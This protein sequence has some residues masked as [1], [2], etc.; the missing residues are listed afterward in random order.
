M[1]ATEPAPP[2]HAAPPVAPF[3]FPSLPGWRTWWAK[4]DRRPIYAWARDHI[5]LPEG[6]YAIPGPFDV[7]RSRYLIEPFDAIHDECVREITANGAVQTGKTLLADIS[8]PYFVANDPGAMM[9]T[10]QSDKDAAEHVLTRVDRLWRTIAPLAPL[11]PTN[12]H[13]DTN[14]A[15]YF[16]T[17]FLLINGAN[18]NSLQSKSIR[19]KFN[20]E[21][22]LPQW[23][24]LY[25]QAARRVSAYARLGTSKIINDSQAGHV[26]DILDQR[27]H[28]G[29]FA[30]WSAPCP[31]CNQVHPLRITQKLPDG[32][33]YGMIW[34][35]DARRPDGTYNIG[36][37]VETIR[38]RCACGHELPDTEHTRQYWNTHGLYVAENPSAPRHIRSYWWGSVHVHPMAEL[39]AEK[40][41]ALNLAHTGNMDDLKTFRQQRENEPWE[42]QHLTV[43]LA[44]NPDGYYTDPANITQPTFLWPLGSIDERLAPTHLALRHKEK[45]PGERYR[46]LMADRQRGMAGD[47]PHRW[48]E[49]RAWFP[50]G[51][52][53]Q[54]T[55]TRVDTKEAMRD[56]QHRYAVPDRCV[57][58]DAR[59]E[60]HKVYEECA[61]YGWI[62]CWGHTVI[63]SWVHLQPNPAGAHLPPVKIRLP[64]SPWQ[65]TVVAGKTV[66][67]LLFA[68][69]YCKDIL[70]NLIAGRGVKHE[71]PTD[72]LPAYLEHLKCEH[73]EQKGA[74]MTWVKRHSTAPNHG[75]DTS[76][77]GI[78]FALLMKLLSMP[79][80][81]ATEPAAGE[82]P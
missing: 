67:Y 6:A 42:E 22:W 81:A 11:Y 60:T 48:C 32:T 70:A 78:A 7:T 59:F 65:S 56:L 61:E 55:F 2:A 58:M 16:A 52:S 68:S 26:G 73:K 50:G 21:L 44:S 46:T 9:W 10:F 18:R 4:P 12:R 23:Q 19:Y 71:H 20:S 79:K 53:K 34:A 45:L 30:R 66:H 57:W 76:T 14:E 8:I 1:T 28:A 64:F 49:V 72:V 17:C 62:A 27:L 33:R 43:T 54:L 35:P 82:G 3:S 38:W 77:Q 69:D 41:E 15:K 25:T 74:K 24:K 39:A 80:P 63:N 31:A 47:T 40:A 29:H 37:C 13:H 36:R 5:V 75:W 51:D